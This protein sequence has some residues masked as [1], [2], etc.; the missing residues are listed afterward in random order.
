LLTWL[1]QQDLVLEDLTQADVE[2]WSEDHP[3]AREAADFL[4]WARRRRFTGQLTI[5]Y[6]PRTDPDITLSEDDRW[7][8]LT[9][10]LHDTDL[11][12]DLRVAGTLLL[13]HG[14]PLTRIVEL[15]RDHL[16]PSGATTARGLRIATGSPA[17]VVPP[18]LGRLLTQ[19]PATPRNP[20]AVALIESAEQ[21]AWLFPGRSAHGN[22]NASVVAKR[23]KDQGIPT[24]AS[25]NAALIA[26]AADLPTS[27]L[28]D[29]FGISITSAL[30]WTH[31]ASRD[32]NTYVAATI[33]ERT[34]RSRSA[35]TTRFR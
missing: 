13:L 19:L 12:T 25:R 24:R 35:N 10:S 7:R 1:D 33:A 5:P 9:K 30:Q 20:S 26:L 8:L 22:V 34:T 2:R 15:T 32:W 18:A 27:V 16:D 14:L 3:T 23:L 21:P 31:R 4:R 6:P 11:P 29:P 28:S 17:V